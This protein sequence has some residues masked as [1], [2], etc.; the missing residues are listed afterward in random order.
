MEFKEP[1]LRLPKYPM[2]FKALAESLE[3]KRTNDALQMTEFLKKTKVKISI[4]SNALHDIDKE[5]GA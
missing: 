1:E 4:F 2:S 3:I 5:I